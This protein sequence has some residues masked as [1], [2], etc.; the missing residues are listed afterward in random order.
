MSFYDDDYPRRRKGFSIILLSVV[1]AVIGGLLSLSL[2]PVVYGPGYLNEKSDNGNIVQTKPPIV[3]QGSNYFSPAV[4]I[5]KNVGPTVVGITNLA[6]RRNFYG[7]ELVEQG[8]GSGVIISSEGYVVTNFHVIDNAQKIVVNLAD[9]RQVDA[10]INGV[11]PE[12]DLA[13]LKIE[14]DNLPVATLGES[15]GLRVGEMVVAIGNPLGQEFARSVTVGVISAKE[16]N[17]TIGERPFKLIQ[18]DAAINPGNSG[19]AL[20]NTA[21]E[22]IGINSAKLVIQG[23]EGMG[24]AIPISDARPIIEQL[25]SKGYISRPSLG[26][27]GVTVSEVD[28]KENNVPQGIYISKIIEGEPADKAGLKT[29]DI[30]TGIDDKE[31]KSFEDLY[32]VLKAYKPGDAIKVHFYRRGETRVTSLTLGERTSKR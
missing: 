4:D 1:S 18:T 8:S 15:E 31:I 32:D 29:N 19:G 12:T 3:S 14:A 10:K 23:V 26:I 21:G 16:R 27:W 6:L 5:A 9:G 13:V 20:V 17:I 22:V 30:I 28:A 11:D 24:F 25:I 7:T 2:V